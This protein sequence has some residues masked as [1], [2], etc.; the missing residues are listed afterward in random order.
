VQIS[1]FCVDRI[2]FDAADGGAQVLDVAGLRAARRDDDAKTLGAV[3]RRFVGALDDG[4][5]R[6]ELVFF[7]GRF[8]NLRLRAVAAIFRA[9]AALRVQQN[10]H[11]DAPSEVGFAHARCRGQQVGKFVGRRIEYSFGFEARKRFAAQGFVGELF[12]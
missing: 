7:D 5:F 12:V 9:D 4:V 10:A 2:V 11:F 3:G 8:G 6:Q 1:R